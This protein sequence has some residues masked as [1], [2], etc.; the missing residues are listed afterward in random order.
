MHPGN[1]DVS[2][3]ARLRSDTDNH[4]VPP[5]MDH[6]CDRHECHQASLGLRT[7]ST[8][9]GSFTVPFTGRTF[10]QGI[11]KVAARGVAV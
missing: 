3:T 6:S 7:R 5:G 9:A 1:E 11:G 2:A 10:A 8:K 4:N